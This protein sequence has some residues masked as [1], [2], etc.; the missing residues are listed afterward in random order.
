MHSHP[1]LRNLARLTVAVG[2][3]TNGL[4]FVA[5][6]ETVVHWRPPRSRDRLGQHPS[7]KSSSVLTA[8]EMCVPA[9]SEVPARH[10]LPSAAR[11][12]V[13]LSQT[14]SLE[15][16]LRN[17]SLTAQEENLGEK[18]TVPVKGSQEGLVYS[19]H[20]NVDCSQPEVFAR[21]RRFE[22]KE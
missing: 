4:E 14:S 6:A 5:G 16:E 8:Q 7:V 13:S 19:T 11:A 21:R 10:S 17:C 22:A 9:A 3:A 1:I 20:L 15:N 2:N 12:Y 18:V